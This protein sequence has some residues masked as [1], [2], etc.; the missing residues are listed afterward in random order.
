[1]INDFMF[2]L[3]TKVIF[4]NGCIEQVGE[5]AK[6]LG[7][8]KIMLVADKGVRSLGI[9]GKVKDSLKAQGLK[10]IDFDKVVPN[11]VIKDCEEGAKIAI[12]E[13][14]DLVVSVGGGSSMDTAKAIAAMMA[15]NTTDFE[16]I[17][18]PNVFTAKV[19]PTIAIPTTA[20]T[21]SEVTPFGVITNE[22]T[23]NKDFFLDSQAVPNV[24]LADPEVLFGLPADIAASTGVD[25]LT[26]AIEGYVTKA[27][28][29]ITEA[30]GIY[31]IKLLSENLRK[32]VYNR[33]SESCK[34]MLVGSLLAGISFGFSDTASVHSMAET[35]G[36]IYDAPHGVSNAIFLA[37]VTEFSIPGDVE[38]YA[39]IAKAMGVCCSELSTRELAD[40]AVD[41]IKLLVHDL[42]IPKFKDIKGVNPKDFPMIAERCV[43]HTST[44]N[45][46]RVFTKE[47]YLKILH[48]AYEA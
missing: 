15:H 43:E 30:C 38:K 19:C 28:N 26:H 40:A 31:A 33:D 20:G 29:P 16:V 1:M 22:K 34:A 11:P 39:N 27:T 8:T 17:K 18:Y 14:I 3:R 2:E 7:G 12:K 48:E 13:K 6:E 42:A 41:E 25:A 36:G 24:A 5:I 37:P 4:G 35:I 44:G 9:T 45:N 47:D 21:G 10:V 23:L 46:P 32:F